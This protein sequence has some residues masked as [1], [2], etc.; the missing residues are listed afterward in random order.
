M[1]VQVLLLC[2]LAFLGF[3]GGC[4]PDYDRQLPNGYVLVRSNSYTVAIATPADIARHHSTHADAGIAV[5][6]KI[7]HIAVYSPYVVGEVVASP[8]SELADIEVPGWF[9]LHTETDVA[10]L[11]LTRKI[12][13]ASLET[14]GLHPAEIRLRDPRH[15]PRTKYS[16]ATP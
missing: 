5:A 3:T 14:I 7:I 8:S 12:W 10:Q 4:H 6:A 15:L 11:G 13:E 9:I 16:G 2:S 1:K